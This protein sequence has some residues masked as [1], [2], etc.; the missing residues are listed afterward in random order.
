MYNKLQYCFL[1]EYTHCDITQ[2]GKNEEDAAHNVCAAPRME[3]AKFE[4]LKQTLCSHLHQIK[5]RSHLHLTCC[6]LDP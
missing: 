1:T 3:G 5:A 4:W 6:G 2:Y